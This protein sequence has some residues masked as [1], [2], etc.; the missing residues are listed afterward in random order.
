MIGGGQSGAEVVDYLLT[1]DDSIK[2]LIW[3]SKRINFHSLDDSCFANEFHSPTYLEYFY[4]LPNNADKFQLLKQQLM[5]SD[6]IT[7][8]LANS[9]YNKIYNIKH[10]KNSSMSL[11]LIPD[12]KLNMVE[13]N[14]NSSS[15]YHLTLID[16]QRNTNK[17]IDADVV[18]L[19]TGY[20]PYLPNCIQDI[21]PY[22]V[23]KLI[24]NFD[25]SVNTNR[26]GDCKIFIQNISKGVHG[27]SDPN[28]S[29]AS[30]RNA[31]IINSILNYQLYNID[32][33][34]SLVEFNFK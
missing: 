4:K 27:I 11:T 19:T 17:V 1:M 9:I 32:N 16:N 28:L 29:L 22:S 25:Y 24:L 5:T 7:E 3:V 18:I 30:F 23:D 14:V 21:L 34:K 6:G 12:H 33:Q 10:V 13:T 2:N 20:K 8:S 15:K 26:F 31:M